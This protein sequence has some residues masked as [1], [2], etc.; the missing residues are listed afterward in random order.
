MSREEARRQLAGSF[1]FEL[2]GGDVLVRDESLLDE[3]KLMAA[4]SAGYQVPHT[5]TATGMGMPVSARYVTG[6]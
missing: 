6:A 4:E 2:H 5:Q 3:I 1:R